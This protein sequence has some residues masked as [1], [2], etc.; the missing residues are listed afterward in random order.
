MK[1]RDLKTLDK[2]TLLLLVP[3]GFIEFPIILYIGRIFGWLP[4]FVLLIVM[5]VGGGICFQRKYMIT[6]FFLFLT[7]G[8]ISVVMDFL[9]DLRS[10]PNNYELFRNLS[11]G[12][13]IEGWKLK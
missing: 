1:F 6:G 8:G 3:F 10:N 2:I 11:I 4:L 5:L 7:A 13:F 12:T 9:P